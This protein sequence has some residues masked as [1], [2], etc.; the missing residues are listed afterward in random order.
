MDNEINDQDI[1]RAAMT[2]EAPVAEAA[3]VEE[4][5]QPRDESGRFA[6]KA[7]EQQNPEMQDAQPQGQDVEQ[8]PAR[9]PPGRLRE[10]METRRRAEAELQAIKA[11]NEQL[12]RMMTQSQQR[13]QAQSQQPEQEAPDIFTDP[14]AFVR[15]QVDPY[16]QQ[17]RQ[18]FLANAREVAEVRFGDDVVQEASNAFDQAWQSGKM[19]PAE[20]DRIMQSPNPFKE[21]VNWHKR[22]TVLSRVGDDPEKF[23]Q[24]A[25]DEA[26]NDP[27]FLQKAMERARQMQAP[28]NGGGSVVQ[29]PPSLNRATNAAPPSGPVN[30][31]SDAEIWNAIRR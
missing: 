25:L 14:N 16:V 3:P 27:A 2:D 20:Y 15:S 19:H 17:M 7:Q 29:L 13:P 24:Q 26:L 30:G 21:A 22:Q 4:A 6:A 23:K 9:V 8:I 12:L 5:V 31:G 18:I 28:V 11:Q 1:F 10:E